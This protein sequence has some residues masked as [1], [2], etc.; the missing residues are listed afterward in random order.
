[1]L[2]TECNILL[3]LDSHSLEKLR[4]TAVALEGHLFVTEKSGGGGGYEIISARSSQ[5]S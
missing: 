2:V 4:V 1:M 5:L 3:N